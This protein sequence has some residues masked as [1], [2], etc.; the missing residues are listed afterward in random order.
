M[1]FRL[2]LGSGEI[3]QGF[4]QKTTPFMGEMSD[5]RLKTRKSRL[6]WDVP[7]QKDVQ[8]YVLEKFSS[9]TG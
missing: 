9:P 8:V 3:Y 4:R 1:D 6:F 5:E 2:W 7:L